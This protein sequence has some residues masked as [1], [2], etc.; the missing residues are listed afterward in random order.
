MASNDRGQD[1]TGHFQLVYPTEYIKAP[2]L[3]GKD[4]TVTIARV[5]WE[6]LVM[7][8]GRRDKKA[9]IHMTN[10]RGVRLG[11]RW[12]VGKTVLKQLAASVGS[13]DV[14]QWI[15]RQVTMYPTT[16]KGKAGETMECI[17][18]RVRVSQT[19]TE[20]P[21]DMAQAPAPRSFLDEAEADETAP[22]EVYPSASPAVRRDM[23]DPRHRPDPEAPTVSE[24]QALVNRANAARSEAEIN[25][26]A[27]DLETNKGRLR[28]TETK[29]IR[30][31]I[32]AR[33]EALAGVVNPGAEPPAGQP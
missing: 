17:R 4:V 8:G 11:K 31:L 16:C 18:V 20:I 32:A 3:R 10:S 27:L 5:A 24:A 19:A 23:T 13:P 12:V 22:P 21:E 28:T 1:I 33:R 14:S 7:E 29:E 26:V 9:V 25:L 30:A 2:D 6:N 15:G